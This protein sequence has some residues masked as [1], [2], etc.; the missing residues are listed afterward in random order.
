MMSHRSML[1]LFLV[2]AAAVSGTVLAGPSGVVVNSRFFPLP[3][4]RACLV[5]GDQTGPCI[6][7]DGGGEYYLPDSGMT[8]VRITLAGYLPVEVPAVDQ[9]NPV[10]MEQ[11]AVLMLNVVHETT[12]ESLSVG[13]FWITGTGGDRIGPFPV[14]AAGTLIKSLRPGQIA[15]RVEAAGFS[16]EK[17]VWAELY[18]GSETRVEVPLVPVSSAR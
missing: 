12:R 13:E 9:V 14:S 8:R 17:P 5:E 15:I 11:A 6:L 4:A 16:Q 1:V 2:A 7:T 10:M 3:G 18:A